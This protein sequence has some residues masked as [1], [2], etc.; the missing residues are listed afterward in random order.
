VSV[1]EEGRARWMALDGAGPLP[2]ASDGASEVYTDRAH[3]IALLATFFPAFTS[4]SDPQEPDWL[5]VYLDT[6]EGQLSWH[7]A[8]SDEYLFAHVPALPP[9]QA[10]W[11]GHTTGEKFERMRKLVLSYAERYQ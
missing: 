7:V 2:A 6:P 1:E 4:R 5:V 11:D 10:K 8:A 3:L 9:S